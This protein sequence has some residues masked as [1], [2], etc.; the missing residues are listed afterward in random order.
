M[1]TGPTG[2]WL[3]ACHYFVLISSRESPSSQE[4]HY[5][6]CSLRKQITGSYEFQEKF[7]DIRKFPHFSLIH[8][9]LWRTLYNNF[10]RSWGNV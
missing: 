10:D 9:R 3:F 8:I 5:A 6:I 1:Q 4:K 2:S 7:P